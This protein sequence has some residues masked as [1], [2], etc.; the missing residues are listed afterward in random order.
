[1]TD[2]VQSSTIADLLAIALHGCQLAGAA[3]EAL[4]HGIETRTDPPLQAVFRYEDELDALNRQVNDAVIQLIPTTQDEVHARQLIAALK[5]I[6]ELE[7]IG[8]LFLNVVN[9]FRA[10]APRLETNDIQELAEMTKIVVSMLRN[11]AEAFAGRDVVR[12][13]AVLREDAELDRLRNLMLVRH[14][15]NPE[16]LP[17]GE[18]Y[19]VV[20]MA[21]I[22]ERSGDHVKH[23]AEEICH[24][25][26]G[27]SVRHLLRQ[28]EKPRELVER[29]RNRRSKQRVGSRGQAS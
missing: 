2:L 27:R 9:R 13:I 25:V 28:Y 26:T 22:L 19:H 1:M 7:R 16:D 15:E 5:F 14:V 24:L 4:L 23:L 29:D 12:A 20:F 3:A 11:V 18:S 10:A 17:V 8:D 6:I 21:Q